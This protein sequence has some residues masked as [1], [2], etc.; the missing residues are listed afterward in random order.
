MTITDSPPASPSESTQRPLDLDELIP[1]PM[2]RAKKFLVALLLVGGP[3]G[4]FWLQGAGYFSP[5]PLM[6]VS[7]SAPQLIADTQ[8]GL[9]GAKFV[10]AN[11]SGR[12]VRLK[13]VA[14]DAP[15]AE[16]AHVDL[17]TRRPDGT[18]SSARIPQFVPAG[19]DGFDLQAV[20]W[21]RPTSCVDEPGPW[22]FVEA[23]FDF[24]EGSFP[25]IAKT[26]LIGDGPI[27]TGEPDSSSATFNVFVDGTRGVSGDGPLAT[28]CE[29]VQ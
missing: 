19:S 6:G 27:W 12:D 20:V 22:G 14:L 11:T 15:G 26:L 9:V 7:Q 2:S 24:G 23:T 17:V 8:S 29:A 16:V 10:V 4:F 28:A 21:F 1:P 3:I 18:F 5:D 13:S 25:P